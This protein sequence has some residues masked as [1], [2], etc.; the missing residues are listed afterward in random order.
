[1]KSMAAATAQE[2]H[3]RSDLRIELLRDRT[4]IYGIGTFVGGYPRLD[5][6]QIILRTDKVVDAPAHDNRNWYTNAY[7]RIPDVAYRLFGRTRE[8][9]IREKLF[10]AML[11]RDGYPQEPSD[12]QRTWFTAN[13]GRYYSLKRVSFRVLNNLIGEAIE[14]AADAKAVLM[15]RRFPIRI[16]QEL[17]ESFVREGSRSIQLAMT[18]PVLAVLVYSDSV[19]LENTEEDV[20][21][22]FTR[23]EARAMVR[24]GCSL[25]RIAGLCDVP[26]VL[27]KFKPG[28]A[29]TA[30]L[31]GEPAIGMQPP[32][33]PGSVRS[34]SVSRQSVASSDA[35]K[36][37]EAVCCRLAAAAAGRP[38]SS[39]IRW[40]SWASSC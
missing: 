30:L 7:Q 21:L 26:M 33:L 24:R 19:R 2:R 15:A 4:G 12:G 5:Q 25:R 17:Y 10:S 27:Q 28:V 14:E 6:W 8:T 39:S 3:L 32:V 20:R 22:L 34:T 35:L 18:F 31:S 36:V 11:D 13:R 1:M 37:P 9:A 23:A 38:C 16:R 29:K 40:S